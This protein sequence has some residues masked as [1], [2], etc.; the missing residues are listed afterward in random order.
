MLS[1]SHVGGG[2]ANSL[3]MKGLTLDSLPAI[4][5]IHVISYSICTPPLQAWAHQP[6][7]HLT[8]ENG[9]NS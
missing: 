9:K 7:H 4:E 6:A 2:I 3:C 8:E 1:K 5:P